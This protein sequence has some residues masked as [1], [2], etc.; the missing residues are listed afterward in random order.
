[1]APG[2]GITETVRQGLQLIA[3]GDTF[4]GGS[5]LRGRVKFSVSAKQLREDRE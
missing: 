4:R 2:R 5:M 3:S 1:M